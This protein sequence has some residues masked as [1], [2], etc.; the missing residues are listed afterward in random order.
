LIKKQ[1]EIPICKKAPGLSA[2]VQTL[3]EEYNSAGAIMNR[4]P[5]KYQFVL[6]ILNI[7]SA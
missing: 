2:G 3:T 1:D 4:I 7:Y 5:S 6:R